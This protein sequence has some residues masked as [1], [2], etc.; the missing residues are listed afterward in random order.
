MADKEKLLSILNNQESGCWSNAEFEV[1]EV[2]TTTYIRITSHFITFAFD[3]F[4]GRFLYISN[5]QQ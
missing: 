2:E 3:R 5:Y 1:E 4:S